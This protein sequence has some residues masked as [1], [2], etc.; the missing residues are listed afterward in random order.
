[1]LVAAAPLLLPGGGAA[2]ILFGRHH[3]LLPDGIRWLRG[4]RGRGRK[5]GR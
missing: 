4:G 3:G 1:L 2:G 5:G